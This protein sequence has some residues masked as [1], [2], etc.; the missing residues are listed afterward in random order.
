MTFPN[1][2]VMYPGSSLHC[3]H[4]FPLHLIIMTS[5]DFNVPYSYMCTK[6]INHI[7]PPLFSF[8]L[9]LLLPFP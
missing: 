3:S 6:Y 7:Y 5:T 8:F 4:S 2:H 9:L 1:M